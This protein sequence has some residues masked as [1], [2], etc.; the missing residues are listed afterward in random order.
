MI[1]RLNLDVDVSH[2]RKGYTMTRPLALLTAGLLLLLCAP[3]FA[4]DQF[5]YVH[6]SDD[7][8]LHAFR[9]GKDGKPEELGSS[10]VALPGDPSGGGGNN[11]S[12]AADPKGQFLFVPA[13][14]GLQVLR[15]AKDGSV[16]V[17]EGSPF[18][19]DVH[20]VGL[21][22][23]RKGKQLVVFAANRDDGQLLTYD[24]NVTTGVPTVREV[25]STIGSSSGIER[26][27]HQTLAG[28]GAAPVYRVRRTIG[29]QGSTLWG[30]RRAKRR[31]GAQ[32]LTG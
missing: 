10:P 30:V 18:G 15:R 11:Q 3:V 4:K 32:E 28:G 14:N 21:A 20:L 17:V 16:S 23:W 29:P 5:L 8:K 2:Q 25:G 22:A 27:R 24:V 1:L 12:I 9:L 7:A 6:D 31:A 13:A 19:P 26:Q